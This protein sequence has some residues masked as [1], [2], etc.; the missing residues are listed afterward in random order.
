MM[1]VK[2]I[3]NTIQGEGFWTGR[4]ATFVRFSGC[5]LWNGFEASRDRAV[6]KFCDTNFLGG[7]AYTESE[8]ADEINALSRHTGFVVFTGGEPSLQLTA[9][10]LR[11]VHGFR[12]IETNGT[13]ELPIGLDWVTV[14]PKA[15]ARLA[16]QRADE[17]KVIWPQHGLD[18]EGLAAGPWF[19]RFVQPMDGPALEENTRACVQWVREHPYWRLSLQTHKLLGID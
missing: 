18:M 11:K 10:L 2:S 3:F 12:A 7:E 19:H 5:N 15:G 16:I 4:A 8:L 17:C 13:R 1:W 14:S 6:C 9:G